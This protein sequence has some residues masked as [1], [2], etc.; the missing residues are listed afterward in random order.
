MK[1]YLFLF[2]LLF[3][4]SLLSCS[5]ENDTEPMLEL[6]MENVDFHREA[7]FAIVDVKSL[8]A[9]WVVY[10]DAEGEQWCKA[11]V[12]NS[13]T[14]VKISATSNPNKTVRST[15]VTVRNGKLDKKILVRQLGTDTDILVSPT[16]FTLTPVGGAIEFVVTT[17]LTANELELTYPSWISRTDLSR[18]ATIDVAYKFKIASYDE[19][20]SRTD[21]IIIKDKNS[22]ISVGVTITQNGMDSFAPGDAEGLANDIQLE[23]IR[24]EATTEHEGEE[25]EKSFDGDMGTIYHSM[26]PFPEGVTSHYP[27]TLTYY[28]KGDAESLDY[29]TYYPRLSGTNG[30][31]GAVEIQV[32]T[33]NDPG[34]FTSVTAQ[35]DYNFGSS[36]AVATFTFNNSIQKPEAVRLIVKSGVGGHASCAEM[37]FFAKGLDFDPFTLFTDVTCSELKPGITDEDIE[38]CEY[39]FFK[40]IA[41]YMKRDKYPKQFR[42]ASFKAYE[43]PDRQAAFNKTSP[44]SMLDNPTG[45]FVDAGT[46]IVMVGEMDKAY[47]DIRIQDMDAPNGDGFNSSVTYSLRTGINKIITMK[48]GLVYIMY[49][50]NDDP[51]NHPEIKVHFA[52]GNINGY[53]DSSKHTREQWNILVNGAVDNYFDV[54]GKYAHL[55]FPVSKLKNTSNGK[56][57]IDIF[58]NIV[59]QE[60]LFL[61]LRKYNNN[62]GAGTDTDNR[63]FRNR[64]YFN[65]MYGQGDYMYST[66]YHTAYNFSTMD[67]LCSVDQMKT[68]NWGPAHEVGHSNQTRPGLRWFGLT[69]VTNNICSMHIQR[70]YNNKS[71][72]ETTAP[73]SSYSNYYEHAM[74]LAFSNNDVFHAKLG[75]VFDKLVPFW[76]LELYMDYVLGKKDFYKDVYEHV[77]ANPNLPTDGERQIE[78][79]FICSKAAQL[80][81]TDYFVKWGFLTAGSYAF[82]DSYTNGKVEVTQTQVNELK[83][84]IKDLG[85][86]APKH[87]FEYIC[88]DNLLVYQNVG[89]VVR[90]TAIRSGSKLTMSGWQNVVAYEITDNA[91]KII[92]VSPQ[93]S[94]TVSTT[95]PEGFKVNAIA[96]NGTKT[97]VTF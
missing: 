42:I 14:S 96:A 35:R 54:V 28:F 8:P 38:A 83:N 94:F 69:E 10:V 32:S 41:Y 85:Y 59:Y 3:V 51:A 61:G 84:R 55:T 40:N 70:L 9:D 4:L 6:S 21:K 62:G 82:N 17:N 92:F 29:F 73:N 15:N 72:L 24:G 74:T 11:E 91:G 49:H 80:D 64:M 31:F 75:D 44:Y 25:I 39:P 2:I 97:Q 93:S 16:L 56:D 95:L 58:D 50:V 87:H 7:N 86:N 71:R 18:A 22:N 46:M 33:R 79:A 67:N 13:G 47:L 1:N 89:T 27:V 30:Y 23:I 76:Q 57:L 36:G 20:I 5:D 66:S 88:D 90:G 77:R 37:K 52:S 34:Q 12:D 81:L 68:N 43:Y 65:V 53:F 60:Q 78:F 26:Y 63:M 19:S 45:I 48:K